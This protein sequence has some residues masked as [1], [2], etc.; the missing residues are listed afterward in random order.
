MVNLKRDYF[1][2]GTSDSETDFAIVLRI[3]ELRGVGGFTNVYFLPGPPVP[4]SV[5]KA[6][7]KYQFHLAHI[8]MVYKINS[9][10]T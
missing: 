8:L 6:S 1:E 10:Q 4:N 7:L 5:Q 9:G 2:L 3:V